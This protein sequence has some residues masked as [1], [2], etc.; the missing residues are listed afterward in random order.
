MKVRPAAERG[1]TFFDWLD[2]KHSFS[3][4]EYYDPRYQGFSSLRVINDD[5]IAAGG[6]FP[7]HPHR[8]ME[9]LT[10][11]VEGAL[12]HEDSLGNGSVIRPGEIQRMTAGSGIRHSEYNHSKTEQLRLLQIWFTPDSNSLAPGY[13]Q[14]TIAV[15]PGG[16]LELIAAPSGSDVGSGVSI[17]QDVRV[18]AALPL[19]GDELTLKCEEGRAIWVQIIDGELRLDDMSIAA[20]DGLFADEPEKTILKAVSNSHLLLFDLGRSN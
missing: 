19:A 4:G 14:A 3:F 1:S 10:Y 18:Y 17:H 6:G 20:G 5:V 8:N 11:V 15:K 12:E 13:E 2:S 7:T 9:I 16:G